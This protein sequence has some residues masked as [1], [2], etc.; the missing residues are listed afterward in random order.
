MRYFGL[1]RPGNRQVLAQLRTMLCGPAPPVA[2]RP[3]ADVP[4]SDVPAVPD[5]TRCPVCGSAMELTQI[6]QPKSRSPPA[7]A[8]AG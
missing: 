7:T 5:V 6:V 8:V 4:T 2:A 3:P 1:F